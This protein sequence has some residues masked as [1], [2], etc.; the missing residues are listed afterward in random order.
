MAEVVAEVAVEADL[1]QRQERLELR[2]EPRHVRE[3]EEDEDGAEEVEQVDVRE[4]D[5]EL[6]V[7]PLLLLAA[8][9][10]KG[11]SE[12]VGGGGGRWLRR[13]RWQWQWQ[14]PVTCGMLQ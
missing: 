6:D 11:M 14:Q 9:Q 4:H 3:V 12:D 1:A 2:P 8:L 7:L 10:R 13:R 5:C